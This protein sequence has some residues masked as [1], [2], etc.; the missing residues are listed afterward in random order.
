MAR[1]YFFAKD[2]ALVLLAAQNETSREKKLNQIF[3][4]YVC[5]HIQGAVCIGIYKGSLNLNI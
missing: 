2:T 3:W 1:D 5:I 4:N